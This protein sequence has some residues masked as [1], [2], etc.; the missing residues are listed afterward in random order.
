[1]FSVIYYFF[2]NDIFAVW[3]WVWVWVYVTVRVRVKFKNRKCP[4]A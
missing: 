2:A 4:N 3:V 1:M